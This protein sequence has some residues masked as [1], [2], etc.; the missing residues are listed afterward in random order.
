MPPWSVSRRHRGSHSFD[1]FP[2]T[3]WYA[4]ESRFRY[5]DSPVEVER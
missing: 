2:Q 3:F 1:R 5:T 4:V